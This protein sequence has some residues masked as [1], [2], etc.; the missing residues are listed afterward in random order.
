MKAEL[1]NYEGQRYTVVLVPSV[2]DPTKTYRV[3]VVNQRCD[4]PAWKFSR[5][6]RKLCK[7]LRQLGFAERQMVAE[8]TTPVTR[9]QSVAQ[10]EAM[11]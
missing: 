3:D 1:V 10:M 5:G 2:S 7:H 4:C 11:L 6:G 8:P 9:L